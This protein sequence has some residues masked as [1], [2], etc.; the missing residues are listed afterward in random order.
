MN[1]DISMSG[2]TSS[3]SA[4]MPLTQGSLHVLVCIQKHSKLPIQLV[5]AIPD[6]NVRTNLLPTTAP[7]RGLMLNLTKWTVVKN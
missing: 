4:E 6:Q 3:E 7:R 2:I 5:T 1:F